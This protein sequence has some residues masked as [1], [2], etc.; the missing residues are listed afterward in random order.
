MRTAIYG[1]SF[2]P[3][4][5][6]HL[7]LIRNVQKAMQFDRLFLIPAGIPPHKSAGKLAGAEE[8]IEMCN[9]ALSELSLPA[10]VLDLEVRREGK[11]YTAET[12]EELSRRYPDDTFTLIMGEDMFRTLGSWWHFEEIFRLAQICAV[13][14]SEDGESEMKRIAKEYEALGARCSIV[15]SDFLDIS[16]TEVREKVRS[17]ESIAS[18]VPEKVDEF[19]FLN[20]LYRDDP[21]YE[22]Y[23]LEIRGKLSDARY[24]HSLCVAKSAKTLAGIYGADPR[25]AEL[26]GILHD[27]LKD[28]PKEEQLQFAERFDIILDNFELQSKTLLHAKLGAAFL[29]KELG[30]S[31]SEILDAVRYHTTGKENMSL[32]TRIIFTADFV[33]DDRVYP[34]VEDMRKMAYG[35]HLLDAMLEGLAFT[36][37]ELSEERR[38]IHPDTLSAYNALIFEKEGATV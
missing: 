32:L 38:V 23:R 24:Y 19:I 6:A 28:T 8:R 1:G 20:G 11:S 7:Q 12:L 22:K 37:K 25:K 33:S 16:S 5:N 3:I 2:N 36:L 10:H 26:A 4:H 9:L 18:L 13:R 17:G 29:E 30:I 27:I 35:N 21:L 14:R 34:G 15:R 31:D